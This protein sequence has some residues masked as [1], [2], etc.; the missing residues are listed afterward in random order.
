[1]QHATN[2]KLLEIYMDL[3]LRYVTMVNIWIFE[4][5]MSWRKC[6]VRD[7]IHGMMATRYSIMSAQTY[8]AYKLTHTHHTLSIGTG[9]TGLTDITG[10]GAASRSIT[11]AYVA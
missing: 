9:V 6:L 4:Y 8:T 7:S 3:D 5:N 2:E 11:I 1:M 10:L